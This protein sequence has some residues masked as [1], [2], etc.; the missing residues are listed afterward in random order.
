[1]L[2]ATRKKL[3]MFNPHQKISQQSKK[4]LGI[5]AALFVIMVWAGLSFFGV[6]SQNKLPSPMSVLHALSYLAYYDGNSMLLEATLAS[7][8]RI[9]IASLLVL[10]IGI[11][12]GIMMGAS[13]KINA[14][15]SPMV[16]P[17]R[18]API[19]A[20][21]PIMVM[22]FGIGE[23]M[24]VI[25]LFLGAVI[26]VMPMVRDAIKAVPY[27]YWESAR[28]L[29]ATK[30]ECITRAILPMAMPRIVDA[31]IASISIQWGYITVAEYVNASVGLGSLIQNARRFSAMDQV[32][33]G[34][35]V[36][37]I[38]AF[39]TNWALLKFKSRIFHWEGK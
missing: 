35:L 28:D 13:P 30:V 36:I 38:L 18:S 25:F 10:F 4:L 11:P 33:A 14:C 7:G 9:L 16:D 23:T 19:V 3:I 27:S 31:F 2:S 37:T 8:S 15:L 12:A 29:G 1:M 39:F 24:K 34:V 21:L 6:V 32:F 26:F 5:S 22:W 20:V 17:F